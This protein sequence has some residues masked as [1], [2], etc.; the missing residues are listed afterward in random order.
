MSNEFEPP[1]SAEGLLALQ[2]LYHVI[3]R[4]LNYLPVDY[5]RRITGNYGLSEG[6]AYK[7]CDILMEKGLLNPILTGGALLFE[8]TPLFRLLED[9]GYTEMWRLS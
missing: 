8:P 1:T 3:F 9:L 5:A 2:L 7:A 6:I 4:K